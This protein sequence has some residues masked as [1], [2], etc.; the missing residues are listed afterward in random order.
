MSSAPAAFWSGPGR[1]IRKRSKSK[2]TI[3]SQS[4]SSTKLTISTANSSSIGSAASSVNS[5]G[6]SSPNAPKRA[7]P[8]ESPQPPASDPSQRLRI[9]FM[10]TPAL[11]AHILEKLIV[12]PEAPFTVV[13]VVT[14]PDQTRKRGLKLEPS[15]V[16]AIAERY[17]L[18]VLKPVKIRTPEF[19]A[20]IEALAPDILAIAAYGR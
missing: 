12:E 1:P 10:G 11:A 13:G 20:E 18:P 15:E 17:A 4:P 3:C 19:L 14:R 2:R 6:A 5:T 9:V 8:M 7:R 16:G